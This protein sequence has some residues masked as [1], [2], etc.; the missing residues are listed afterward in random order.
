MA[1]TAKVFMAGNAQAVQLPDEYRLN[2]D[3][4]EISC[5]GEALILRPKVQHDW[6]RLIEALEAFDPVRFA[7]CFPDGRKQPPEQQRPDM[8]SLLP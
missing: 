6:S 2:V 3:E 4:V 5:E 1:D 8:A 7:D